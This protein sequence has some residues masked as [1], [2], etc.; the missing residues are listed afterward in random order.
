[1]AAGYMLHNMRKY[2]MQLE[3]DGVADHGD[4]E[5]LVHVLEHDNRE[6]SKIFHM[7]EVLKER[8]RANADTLHT[9]LTE[10]E[11]VRKEH[12]EALT[13]GK[14]PPSTSPA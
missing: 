9:I 7:T 10:L 11:A 2:V 14:P 8:E 1:M 13:S 3:D 5:A 12:L 6:V 4:A